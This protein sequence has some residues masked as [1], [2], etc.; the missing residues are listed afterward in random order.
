MTT[1][2]RLLADLQARGMTL[3]LINDQLAWR[4]PKGALTALDRATLTSRRDDIIAFLAAMSG[5]LR[6]PIR[7]NKS[8]VMMPSLL[9]NIWWKWYGRPPRQLN[10][11]RVPLVNIFHNTSLERIDSAIRQLLARHTTLRTSLHEEN[12]KLCMTLNDSATFT[13]EFEELDAG[14]SEA[15]LKEIAAE[16][17]ERQ[18]P[19]DGKWLL[20]AKIVKLSPATF[21]LIFVFHHI[22]VDAASLL[23]IL[24]ELEALLAPDQPSLPPPVQ[25]TDYAAWEHTWMTDAARKPLIDYWARW[26]RN[27][28]VLVAPISRRTLDWQPGLKVDYKFSFSLAILRKINTFALSQHTSLFNVFLT[29]FGMALANW[30][31]AEKFAIRCVGDLRTSLELARIVGYMICSDPVEISAPSDGNFISMLRANEI[32]Y[33]SALKLRL[34]TLLRH[35][36][37]GQS[38]GIEDPRHIAA[39]I[40]MFSVRL[41]GNEDFGQDEASEDSW[42]PQVTRTQG[43][44]WPILLPSIYLRLIDFGNCLQVSLELNDTLLLP[45]E[46]QALLDT[47]FNVVKECQYTKETA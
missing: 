9:Q 14:Y 26:L 19:L 44:P 18:L 17:S 32:E 12:D 38:Q 30:S 15:G 16:F 13:F 28:P 2:P 23:F 24:T 4:A 37:H 43:E 34:P 21:V 20:H 3:S 35:P 39:T 29:A 1:I 27:Q 10:Q 42:P 33:H 47:F 45:D 6:E 25:F 8:Q 41:L 31:G 7:L 5:G 46:Q 40:N 22:I 11:E 36:V